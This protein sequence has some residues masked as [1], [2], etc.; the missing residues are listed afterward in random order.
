VKNAESKDVRKFAQ[1]MIDD[2]SKMRDKLLAQAKSM[3]LGVVQGL[4]EN[5]RKEMLRLTRLS[6]SDFDREYMAGQVSDHEKA[7]SLYEAWSKKAKDSQLRELATKAV[8]TVK[9][10]LRMARDLHGKL[11]K[12]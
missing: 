2:H 1:T 7:L 4:E 9:E 6:G 11:K 3:K 5:H 8:P 12:R 10:H